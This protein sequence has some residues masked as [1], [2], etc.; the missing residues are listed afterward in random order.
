MLPAIEAI[1]TWLGCEVLYEVLGERIFNLLRPVTRPIWR[2]FVVAR[3]PWPLVIA[4]P[5]GVTSVYN[6]YSLLSSPAHADA[7]FALFF[8]GDGVCILTL[9]LWSETRREAALTRG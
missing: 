2:A 8:G 7:G 3:W 1:L 9:I 6:G 4:L 5:L